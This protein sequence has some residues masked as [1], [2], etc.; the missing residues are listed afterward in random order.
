MAKSSKGGGRSTTPVD[1]HIGQKV[2]ARRILLGLSQTE[3]ADAANISFQ[4][5]QKYEKGTNRVGASRL[6]QF[7]EAL[8]VPPSY[9]FEGAPTVGKKQ[10]APQE[11]ELS[12]DTIVSFLGTREGAALVRAFMAIKHKPIRQNAIAFLETLKGK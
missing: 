10:P 11:G 4:Q 7:S 3:L 6:Q 2:R 5:V 12:E 8:G 1:V 9:F